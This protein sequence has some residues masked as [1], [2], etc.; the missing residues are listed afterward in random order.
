[1]GALMLDAVDKFYADFS[2]YEIL[3]VLYLQ[4]GALVDDFTIFLSLLFGFIGAAYFVSDR[5]SKVEKLFISVLYSFVILALTYAIFDG[6]RAMLM[7]AYV[8]TGRFWSPFQY[9]P[10]LGCFAAW[11]SSIWFMYRTEFGAK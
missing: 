10:A 5:L 4:R 7:T 1:M 8:L 11:L 3:D 2:K 9:V 6:T